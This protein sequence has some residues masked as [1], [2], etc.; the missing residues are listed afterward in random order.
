MLYGIDRFRAGVHWQEFVGGERERGRREGYSYVQTLGTLI[1][2]LVKLF[3]AELIDS[4]QEF[5][6]T[7]SWVERERYM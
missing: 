4:G 2:N 3:S 1:N 7:S 5:I 6:G